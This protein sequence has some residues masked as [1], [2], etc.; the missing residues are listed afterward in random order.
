MNSKYLT[1]YGGTVG[2]TVGSV[3]SM[4]PGTFLF[5]GSQAQSSNFVRTLT[6]TFAT[7]VTDF[8]TGYFGN[9][10]NATPGGAYLATANQVTFGTGGTAVTTNLASQACTSAAMNC[11]TNGSGQIGYQGD[12]ALASFSVVT[13]TFTGADQSSFYNGDQVLFDSVRFVNGTGASTTTTTSSSSTT[14]VAGVPEPSTYALIGAG[15]AGLAFARR[16]KK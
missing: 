9:D 15:L 14:V 13:F 10:G 4:P 3:A 5:N 1:T 8:I 7:P 12:G 2:G 6:F 16:K 11:A